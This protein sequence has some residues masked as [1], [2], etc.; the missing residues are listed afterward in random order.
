MKLL[1]NNL[2]I[3]ILNLLDNDKIEFLIDDDLQN[4]KL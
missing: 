4:K 1:I 2:N 3:R